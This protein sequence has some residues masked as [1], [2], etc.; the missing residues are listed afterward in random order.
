LLNEFVERHEAKLK[1]K[2]TYLKRNV[3]FLIERLILRNI[4]K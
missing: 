1:P 3:W 4:K 2:R